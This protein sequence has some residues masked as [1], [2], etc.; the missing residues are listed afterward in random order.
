MSDSMDDFRIQIRRDIN[1]ALN[2]ARAKLDQS[3]AQLLDRMHFT[4]AD[5]DNSVISVNRNKI[6]YHA[7]FTLSPSQEPSTAIY[8]KD[9]G[10]GGARQFH[11]VQ[12]TNE[13]VADALKG[14]PTQQTIE[15]WKRHI[16]RINDE[17][18]EDMLKA[19]KDFEM[20]TEM[21]VAQSEQKAKMELADLERNRNIFAPSPAKNFIDAGINLIGSIGSVLPGS[22]DE[23]EPTQEGQE[24]PIA[25]LDAQ[26]AEAKLHIEGVRLYRDQYIDVL[27]QE[28][29]ERRVG[30]ISEKTPSDPKWL[31]NEMAQLRAAY[32]VSMR[33]ED[34]FTPLTQKWQDAV[35]AFR[36]QQ[37]DNTVVPFAPPI[38][39]LDGDS[40]LCL[41]E[42]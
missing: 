13:E 35:R 22:K 18:I 11:L 16:P 40:Q 8:L 10:N 1:R 34:D 6:D 9:R 17:R 38:A 27:N 33:D 5:Q 23:G 29:Q 24:D 19:L 26:I 21:R 15:A 28:C 41:K 39:T 31:D 2:P 14:K 37:P 3:R 36:G 25:K 42:R 32:E 7:D 20:G 30:L 12:E 4:D